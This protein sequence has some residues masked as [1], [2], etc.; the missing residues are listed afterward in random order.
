MHLR[1]LFASLVSAL[2]IWACFPPQA[3]AQTYPNRPVRFILPAAAGGVQDVVMRRLTDG[4][5]RS[6]GQPVVV[7]NRPG[8]N[9]FIG[10]EAAAR[11]KPDGYTVLFAAVNV[12][13][14]NP[15]LFSEMPYDPVRDFTPVTLAGRGNPILLVGQKLPV[16]TFSEFIEYVRARPGK[17]T[18][19]S[20]A[21][22][23][24]QH[25]AAKLF[26]QLTGTHMVHVPYKNQPQVISDLIGGQIDAA[27]EFP[28]VAVPYVQAGKIRAL[29]IVGPRRKPAIPDIATAAELGLPAFDLAAWNGFLVPTGTPPEIVAR[30]NKEL[31]AALKQPEFVEWIATLGSEVVAS[32][33]DE[34]ASYIAVERVRWSKIVKD[35][36]VRVE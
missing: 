33:P 16:R 27:I 36:K 28:S 15:A 19:G 1:W 18:Y 13:C 24:P 4:L 17:V 29:S 3:L 35:T 32:T 26:E 8:A 2:L 12:L 30:L 22:G 34:F 14:I 31:V 11:A 21:V 20:P 25:I 7:E 10:A 23:S 5:S 6:L 9:G